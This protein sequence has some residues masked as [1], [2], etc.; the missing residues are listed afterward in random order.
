[1]KHDITDKEAYLIGKALGLHER[2]KVIK[3]FVDYAPEENCK[4]PDTCGEICV[5]C[6]ECG[7]K[8]DDKGVMIDDE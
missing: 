6:G 8:F 2:P 7:R 1:M 3:V 5:K 4:S